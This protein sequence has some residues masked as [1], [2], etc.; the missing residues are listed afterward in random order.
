MSD[1]NIFG[2]VWDDG[3]PLFGRWMMMLGAKQEF[4]SVEMMLQI[5]QGDSNKSRTKPSLAMMKI[6]FC[7]DDILV[8]SFPVWPN[9]CASRLME[10]VVWPVVRDEGERWK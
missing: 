7:L 3:D 8:S 1:V 9:D 5:Q 4:V 6:A 2:D 10:M